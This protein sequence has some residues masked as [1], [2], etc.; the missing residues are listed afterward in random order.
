MTPVPFPAHAPVVGAPRCKTRWPPGSS[1]MMCS[2]HTYSVDHH[3]ASFICKSVC[4][5]RFLFFCFF[6]YGFI[7]EGVRTEMKCARF[8]LLFFFFQNRQHK[9][10]RAW[11]MDIWCHLKGWQ[12]KIKLCEAKLAETCRYKCCRGIKA[13]LFEYEAYRRRSARL[14]FFFFL[15]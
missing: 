13:L 3:Y 15:N 12:N 1:V 7:Q 8:S 2:G 6:P 9:A 10:G 4:M 11:G 5:H 14:F